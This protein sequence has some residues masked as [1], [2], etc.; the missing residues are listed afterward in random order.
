M[1]RLVLVSLAALAAASAFSASAQPAATQS[2]SSAAKCF[3]TRDLRNHT[4]GDDH[5]LYFDVG[6]RSVYRVTTSDNCLAGAT[7]SDPIV[8]R[9]RASTGQICNAL[10]WDI[11]V[12]GARCIVSG[13]SVLT[14][15]EK[16]ALP[17]RVR[18]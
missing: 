14:P 3:F 1:T 15:E 7:S 10:D 5:T 9:D 13:M 11:S 8:L 16:A 12:H 17:R 2:S 4:V 6:G 18:P